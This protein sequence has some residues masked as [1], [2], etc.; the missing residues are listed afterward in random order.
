MRKFSIV[1]SSLL[2]GALSFGGVGSALAVTLPGTAGTGTCAVLDNTCMAADTTFVPT[3]VKVSKS[4]AITSVVCAGTTT[5]KPTKAT[6]CDGETL[7]G[8]TTGE[9]AP[10]QPCTITLG[11]T[12]VTTDDWLEVITPSGNVK[13]TCK[14]GATDTK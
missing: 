11:T 9:T 12:A 2:V 5:K 1:S 8:T 14:A 6:K 10:T 13:L 7:G 4:G 3:S